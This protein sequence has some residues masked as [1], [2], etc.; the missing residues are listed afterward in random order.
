MADADDELINNYDFILKFDA[1]T[2][3]T[4]A[5]KNYYPAQYTTVRSGSNDEFAKDKI[6]SISKSLGLNHRGIFNIGSTHYGNAKLV[7]EV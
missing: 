1:A 4:P 5:W 2:F 3:I 6:R 7:K